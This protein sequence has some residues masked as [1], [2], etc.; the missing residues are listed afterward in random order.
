MATDDDFVKRVLK[1]IDQRDGEAI[2]GLR[3]RKVDENM[4]ALLATWRATLPWAAKDLY[5]G[6]F[7]DQKDARLEP[8]MLDALE[9]P[10]VDSRAPAIC[11]LTGSFKLFDTF[12][13]AGGWVDPMVVDAAIAKWRNETGLS[14]SRACA[15]CG[16]PH[17]QNE[18]D[19]RFCHAPLKREAEDPGRFRVGDATFELR[20]GV[21]GPSD[22]PSELLVQNAVKR[23]RVAARLTVVVGAFPDGHLTLRLFE[24]RSGSAERRDMAHQANVAYASWGCPK[25]GEYEVVITS[26]GRDEREVELARASLRIV[27]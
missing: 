21:P 11:Y 2:E 16:A 13:T 1:A 5:V 23:G 7:M 17:R 19:C 14:A 25:A 12:L 24:A 22:A 15:R 27:L 20:I 18:L 3:G 26:R 6:L 10:S 9:S 8:M 4:D